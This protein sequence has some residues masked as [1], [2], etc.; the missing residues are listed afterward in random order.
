[1]IWFAD[2]FFFLALVNRQD[3]AH[4]AAMALIERLDTRILTTVWVLTE[5]SDAL[6]APS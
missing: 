5:V 1:M 4:P 6:A 3:T 2:T